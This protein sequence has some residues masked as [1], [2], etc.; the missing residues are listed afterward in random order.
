MLEHHYRVKLL[1]R[2]S[3]GVEP[4][5]AGRAALQQAMPP[6]AARNAID[7]AFWDLEA[8]R[9]GRPVHALLGG[10]KHARL[11]CYATGG[12]SNYPLEKLAKKMDH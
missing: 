6:G 8:K 3:R 5:P 9:A 11:P 10:A 12:P 1:T 2:T 4:T 7:C